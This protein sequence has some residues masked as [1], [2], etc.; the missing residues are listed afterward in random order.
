[1]IYI[2]RTAK[3]AKLTDEVQ[4]VLTKEYLADTQKTVWNK[5]F[6]SEELLALSHGKCC[7]C[8]R[9]VGNGS[10]DMHVDHFKPK[11]LYPNE[12]VSWNNLMPSCPDCNRNKSNHDTVAEPIVNPCEDD[13]RKYF[14]LKDFRYKAFDTA[15]NSKA[16]ITIDVLRLNDLSKKCITRFQVTSEI[17]EKLSNINIFAKENMTVLN[18]DVRKRNKVI[19]TCRDL[20]EYCGPTAEFSAFTATALQKD[21]DYVELRKELQENGLWTQELENLDKESKRCVFKT[22]LIAEG[23]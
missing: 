19:S 6:I 12:V 22:S 9:K 7:Y 2:E 16:N 14:Y 10:V 23:F 3:P 18:T 17:L 21:S 1:M 4:E 8:E 15:R 13:P 20:L 11:S 5:S